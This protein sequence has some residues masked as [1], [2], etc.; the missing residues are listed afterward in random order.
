[1]C[2]ACAI[3]IDIERALY[4]VPSHS[5]SSLLHRDS[6][7]VP[8]ADTPS[9]E[10][11]I[12]CFASADHTGG[13]RLVTLLCETSGLM[14]ASESPVNHGTYHSP[15]A[16]FLRSNV[17]SLRSSLAR[18]GEFIPNKGLS[19]IHICLSLRVHISVEARIN[20]GPDSLRSRKSLWSIQQLSKALEL[21]ICE[22]GKRAA[23]QNIEQV[24]QEDG[25]HGMLRWSGVPA[26]PG[27]MTIQG[28]ERR[29][30][31]G[32]IRCS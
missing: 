32:N 18:L 29:L 21:D 7:S 3:D 12:L 11:S 28:I 4:F 6:Y 23:C 24:P 31:N 27:T 9:L 26:R 22:A 16:C 25:E 15:L 30:A 5:H 2:A 1:M 13:C 14:F 17:L 20:H 19:M 8:N 10:A